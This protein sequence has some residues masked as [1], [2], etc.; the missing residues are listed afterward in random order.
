MTTASRDAWLSTV[1]HTL[2]KHS[3]E[4]VMRATHTYCQ[5]SEAAKETMFAR[6]ASDQ[7]EQPS[8]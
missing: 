3:Y 5:G 7:E 4:S 6:H 2:K 1:S 8:A